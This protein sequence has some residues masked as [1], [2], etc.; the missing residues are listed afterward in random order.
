MSTYLSESAEMFLA[1]LC[2]KHGDG[3]YVVVRGR[4][5]SWAD[6]SKRWLVEKAIDCREQSVNLT[7]TRHRMC[8]IHHCGLSSEAR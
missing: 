2:L 8:M 3:G 5:A 6:L 1:D 7:Y 4:L